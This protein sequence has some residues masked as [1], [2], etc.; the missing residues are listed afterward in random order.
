MPQIMK[1][2]IQGAKMTIF[3]YEVF[4]WWKLQAK[5][6]LLTDL[7]TEIFSEFTKI[8]SVEAWMISTSTCDV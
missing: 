2:G 4:K 1:N 6:I 5:L 7:L 8:S 3:E